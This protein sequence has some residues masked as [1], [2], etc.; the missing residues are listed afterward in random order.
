MPD[1]GL[2]NEPPTR[3][4]CVMEFQWIVNLAA[5]GEFDWIERVFDQSWAMYTSLILGA[6]GVIAYGWHLDREMEREGRTL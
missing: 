4:D 5:N 3:K 1:D 6:I 2:K